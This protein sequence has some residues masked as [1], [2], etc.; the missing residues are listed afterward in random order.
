[1]YHYTFGGLRNVWLVNGY[2]IKATPHGEA[3]A[4]ADGE[5]LDKAI[6]MALVDKCGHLTGA[7]FRF[8]RTSGFMLSQGN[9]GK[10]IGADVQ[11]V[12]R[13]EKTGRIPKWADKLV[14]LLFRGHADGDAPIGTA[15]RRLQTVDRLVNQRI[16]MRERQGA[17]VPSVKTMDDQ[18]QDQA[19]AVAA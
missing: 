4:F 15:I 10:M 19:D 18:D 11:S 13:W 9:L 7:E 12:A 3:V 8:I 14:R 5:G 1:M 16:V 2:K 6:C 17:W